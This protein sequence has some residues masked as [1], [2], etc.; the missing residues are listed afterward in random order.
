MLNETSGTV[1][2]I[3]GRRGIGAAVV[4]RAK[5][6][7]HKVVIGYR[8]GVCSNK[9]QEF[10]FEQVSDCVFARPIDVENAMNVESFFQ[11]VQK[12]LGR[13]SAVVYAAGV[14]GNPEMLIHTNPSSISK[15]LSV[16]LLGAFYAVQ[17]AS[18]S[19]MRTAGGNGGSIV[20]VTSE[21]GK[22][23]GHYISPYAAS[24]A[25]INAMVLGA[26]RELIREGIRLNAVSPGVI[27]TSQHDGLSTTRR[28]EVI[29][30]IPFGRMGTPDEVANLVAWLISD[31]SIYVVGSIM[32][33]TGGR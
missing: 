6:D 29:S 24:K 32:S 9:D 2:V 18:R 5:C 3:G 27:D 15:T 21:S 4:R 33:I 20:I 17:S 16:N 22:F 26:S 10:L 14:G 30:S 25:G 8:D 1:V 12:S 28:N 7:G 23:G 13:P 19:M 31:E 11:D